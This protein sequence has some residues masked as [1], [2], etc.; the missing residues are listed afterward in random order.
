MVLLADLID[1][2]ESNYSFAWADIQNS[3]QQRLQTAAPSVTELMDP[4]RYPT[5]WC[6]PLLVGDYA[7]ADRDA[8][9][10]DLTPYVAGCV[11]RHVLFD[12]EP[13]L[14]MPADDELVQL[15]SAAYEGCRGAGDSFDLRF[16][17][18]CQPWSVL[19][20]LGTES[21]RAAAASQANC[22]AALR[23]ITAVFACVQVLDDW[24]D[25]DDDL[26][27][28]HWNIWTDEP[29]ARSLT[30]VKVLVDGARASVSALRPHL[31]RDALVTQLR[32]T[33]RELADVSQLHG[34]P[35]I[36]DGTPPADHGI[37]GAVASGVR[38]LSGRL[39]TS[40]AGLW[41]DFSSPEI[42]YGSTECVSAFMATLLAPIP[43][44]RPLA[45]AVSST[46]LARA[47]PSGGWGYRED[48]PEDCDSTAWV[49]LAAATAGVT[50]PPGLIRRS[51]EFI[52][53]HQRA[54]G[55]FATYNDAA[56]AALTPGHQAGWFAPEGSVTCSAA[57]ALAATKYP[58]ASAIRDACA[59]IADHY[60]APGWSSYWWQGL[61][62]GTFMATW[63]LSTLSDGSYGQR[64]SAVQQAMV[65]RRDAD[66]GHP[67]GGDP[68]SFAAA[69]AAL[70]LL[71][72][73]LPP[74]PASLT[75]VTSLLV[76]LQEPL[77]CW[78]PG[79]RML[80][81]G[82]GSGAELI[83]RDEL[84]TTACAV[85]ALHAIRTSAR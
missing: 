60:T 55:G 61:S 56:R 46:L 28:E 53:A 63:A 58:D 34:Q 66:A 79:A 3:V 17:A 65:T 73:P 37:A 38:F 67:A 48:V 85:A 47:R 20:S 23:A 41:R 33:A 51:Q 21:I 29:V 25:R 13:A 59:F 82:A 81:P 54:G 26:T 11:I 24:H 14:G 76:E 7:G 18:K 19:L 49:L 44:G 69:L 22:Q 62:Y 52:V 83:L 8:V 6:V 9:L 36:P 27:R 84:A 35:K 70:T 45:R 30:A 68:D 64:L 72:G 2:A 39:G 10:G 80:A 32:D 1:H 42:S 74:D 43:E 77:G 57:L 16:A 12:P 15:I 75:S 78:P 5:Y 4:H 31:L 71:R 40:T 50:A